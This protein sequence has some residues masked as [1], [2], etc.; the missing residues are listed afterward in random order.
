MLS[1]FAAVIV[2]LTALVAV[3]RS[4]RLLLWCFR[5]KAVL[6]AL[7]I[8]VG[9][10][11]RLLRGLAA[12]LVLAS[13]WA[14]HSLFVKE[15]AARGGPQRA[16]YFEVSLQRSLLFSSCAI[17]AVAPFALLKLGKEGAHSSL[18]YGVAVML[19]GVLTIATRADRIAQGIGL[20]TVGNGVFLAGVPL[21][22]E[23][24]FSWLFSILT[25]GVYLLMTPLLF[26]VLLH[27]AERMSQD[28]EIEIH[29]ELRG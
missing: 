20:I 26:W 15:A 6:I 8:T 28:H 4:E 27:R 1:L 18:P 11:S 23:E 21:T 19:L 22:Q 29:D 12:G 24:T 14:V 13:A 16:R 9:E 5:G 10:G 3:T 17:L 2:L 25:V 7:Y